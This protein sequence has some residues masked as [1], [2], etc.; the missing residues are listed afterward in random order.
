MKSEKIMENKPRK[1]HIAEECFKRT[2]FSLV[3]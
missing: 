3:Q 2:S 1:E